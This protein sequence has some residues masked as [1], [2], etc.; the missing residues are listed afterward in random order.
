MIRVQP[1]KPVWDSECRILILGSIPSTMS[2]EKGFYYMNPQNRFWK[3]LSI[4]FEY[5]LYHCDIEEKKEF[6]L[7]NHIA[8][9]DVVEECEIDFSKDSSIKKKKIGNIAYLIENSL[10]KKVL[11]NGKTAYTL[12]V[13][14]FKEYED[15]AFY[16]PSTSPANARF[17][18]E[19][20]S[21]IWGKELK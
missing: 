12:F 20:L 21:E 14:H 1:F 11:L 3:I 18:L 4:V 17:S 10:I 16:L 13:K 7:K 19:K 6:L 5:D 9:Y 2:I 8:L 15:M